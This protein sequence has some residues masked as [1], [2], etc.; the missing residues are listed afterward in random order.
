MPVVVMVCFARSGGTVLNQCLGCLPGVVVLSEVNRL[1]GGAGVGPVSC[2]TVQDQAWAWYGIRLA[3]PSFAEGIWELDR[4]CES[5]S[6]RLVVR[7]WTYVE[8]MPTVENKGRPSGR[9]ATLDDLEQRG[10][11]VPFAFVRDAID[12]WISRGCPPTDAFFDGYLRYVQALVQRRVP[13]FKY[14]RFCLDPDGVMRR[15][16]GQCG[17]DYSDAYRK[18]QSFTRVNGNVQL[19]TESRGIQQGQIRPL[20]RRWIS[21]ERVRSVN[22]SKAMIQANRLLG[23][24]PFYDGT[25]LR[26][27]ARGVTTGFRSIAAALWPARSRAVDAA[28]VGKA[29]DCG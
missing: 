3:Q 24:P 18:H 10:S 4:V 7:D 22:R 19:G 29:M 28:G 27:A 13:I 8:F 11:V 1:G 23:Y 5:S 9:L 6:R 12:V 16:C 15:L 20:A 14:E 17:L 26:R 25:V 2:Q 21:P